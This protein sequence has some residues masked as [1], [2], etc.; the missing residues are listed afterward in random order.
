M[1][2]RPSTICG[3]ARRR[4]G[5]GGA[6]GRPHNQIPLRIREGFQP[7]LNPEALPIRA[8]VGLLDV[9]QRDAL[10]VLEILLDL[11]SQRGRQL[12]LAGGPRRRRRRRPQ[13]RAL[14][15][16]SAKPEQRAVHRFVAQQPVAQDP[17][18]PHGLCGEE[19]KAVGSGR[20]AAA[21]PLPSTATVSRYS[22]R[23]RRARSGQRP[24]RAPVGSLRA[25]WSPRGCGRASRTPWH[26][27]CGAKCQEEGPAEG[28]RHLAEMHFGQGPAACPPLTT[29][30]ACMEERQLAV[31]STASRGAAHP[32]GLSL[33]HSAS[34]PASIAITQAGA[35]AGAAWWH[36]RT[37]RG[38]TRPAPPLLR[39]RTALF[40]P[41]MIF[42]RR[43]TRIQRNTRER[44]YRAARVQVGARGR[45]RG[46]SS[47]RRAAHAGCRPSSS[48][49]QNQ[50]LAAPS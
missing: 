31:A 12:A 21:G 34:V 45:H 13:R 8:A 23:R 11:R 9:L 19:A 48:V 7:H 2:I 16:V 30:S 37:D 1:Y 24:A 41:V 27:H 28:E 17:G 50:L 14:G 40:L 43:L 5:R 3:R 15:A 6:A 36:V 4:R 42:M 25:G 44:K 35:G 20:L 29:G 32:S 26:G 46:G 33:S 39:L 18:L 10:P 22:P 38:P 47:C 49:D